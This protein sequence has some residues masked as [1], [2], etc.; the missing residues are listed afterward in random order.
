MT[1]RI[2]NPLMVAG[3]SAAIVFILRSAPKVS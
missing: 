3:D 2:S 1:C